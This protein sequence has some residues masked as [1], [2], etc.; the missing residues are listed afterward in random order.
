[1]GSRRWSQ[2]YIYVGVKYAKNPNYSLGMHQKSFIWDIVKSCLI[3]PP[4]P[5]LL[6]AP[7]PS[8]F[9]L[10]TGFIS[11]QPPFPSIN[12]SAFLLLQVHFLSD[13]LYIFTSLISLPLP[14]FTGSTIFT[15]SH[16]IQVMLVAGVCFHIPGTLMLKHHSFTS[17]CL[18]NNLLRNRYL[19]L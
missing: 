15:S 3:P 1:M 11:F 2:K 14:S 7:A 19:A 12:G 17:Q 10:T 8:W 9:F 18:K 6:K 5:L 4:P 16:C 13:L